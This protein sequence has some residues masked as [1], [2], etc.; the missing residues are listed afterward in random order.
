MVMASARVGQQWYK[1][2]RAGD[3]GTTACLRARLSFKA[4]CGVLLATSLSLV[5]QAAEQHLKYETETDRYQLW[6]DGV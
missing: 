3:F 2:E 4:F 1:R 5:L 6:F